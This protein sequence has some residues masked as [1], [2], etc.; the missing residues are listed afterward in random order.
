VYCIIRRYIPF[1]IF[2]VL[3]LFISTQSYSIV[4][5]KVNLLP[6]ASDSGVVLNMSLF[7]IILILMGILLVI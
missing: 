2:S 7:H 1:L 5:F 4:G 3:L 6:V